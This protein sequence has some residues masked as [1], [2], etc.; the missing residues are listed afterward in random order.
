M[1]KT[2]NIKAKCLIA[3]ALSTVMCLTV[4]SSSAFAANETSYDTTSASE[5]AYIANDE[6]D[7]YLE[8]SVT[9]SADEFAD[10]ASEY[11]CSVT[12]GD[13]DIAEPQERKSD[14][15]YFR[16]KM[17]QKVSSG[18]VTSGAMQFRNITFSDNVTSVIITCQVHTSD[19]NPWDTIK[20]W[21]GHSSQKEFTL[22]AHYNIYM[23]VTS[24]EEITN[25]NPAWVAFFLTDRASELV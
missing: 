10:L 17:P 16:N 19:R 21:G 13:E 14:T 20:V 12:I 15:V 3:S 6:N 2:I 23:E 18:V 22:G 9:L 5:T 8:Y 4:V 25:D 1:K 24:D 7:D 11:G